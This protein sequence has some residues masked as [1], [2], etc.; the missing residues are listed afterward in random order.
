[1]KKILSVMLAVVL[2]C[3]LL[4]GCAEKG[5]REYTIEEF[6]KIYNKIEKDFE[7]N[8][9]YFTMEEQGGKKGREEYNK[10]VRK[11]GIKPGMKIII[12]GQKEGLPIGKGFYIASDDDKYK[13]PCMPSEKGIG[14][15]IDDE[16]NIKVSGIFSDGNKSFGSITNAKI[17]SPSVKPVYKDNIGDVVSSL[18]GE[19]AYHSVCGTIKEI[20]TAD[21]FKKMCSQLSVIELPGSTF[22]SDKV[23]LLSSDKDDGLISFSFSP[24]IV[25][26]LEIGDRVALYGDVNSIMKIINADGTYET[27]WGL[28]NVVYEV[29][30]FGK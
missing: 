13:V 27:Q 21:E 9:K 22:L 10:A 1:M 12:R 18:E 8:T 23:A 5:P 7:K 19:S 6:G 11:Q 16:T 29:Y 15:F 24:K 20:V 2:I 4:A 28:I 14:I 17:L 30:N 25:K 3:G 26:D